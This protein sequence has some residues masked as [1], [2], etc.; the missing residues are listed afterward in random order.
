MR[1]KEGVIITKIGDDHVVV[2]AGE[3]AKTFSG[4]IKMNGSAAFI[5]QAM[6]VDTTVE[7]MV[8]AL[9]DKYDVSEDVAL[10]SVNNVVKQLTDVGLVE[11]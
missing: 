2:A 10:T 9:L 11:A 4:M 5:A 8:K 7:D 1:L 6:Q 3:A